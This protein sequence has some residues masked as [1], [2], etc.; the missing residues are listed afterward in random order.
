MKKILA[1]LALLVL[2]GGGWLFASPFMALNG[3]KDAAEAGD[4]G[5]LR[6]RVNFPAFRESLKG[7][8][9][10]GLTAK[11]ASDADAGSPFGKLGAVFA[12]GMV[13]RIV[14]RMVTPEAISGII[15]QSKK[16]PAQAS[17]ESIEHAVGGR[18][19]DWS[20]NR[21]GFN[22]FRLTGTDGAGQPTPELIFERDGLGWD[23]VGIDMGNLIAGSAE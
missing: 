13:D 19:P 3:L 12:M 15:L 9:K 4:E 17:D 16:N 1:I 11:L 10:A 14:D 20:V 8:I 18:E 22:S 2:V 6:E 23:L 21:E 7:E 5:G